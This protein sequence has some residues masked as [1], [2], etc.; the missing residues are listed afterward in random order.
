MKKHFTLILLML[1]SFLTITAC[2]DFK[3]N[4]HMLEA[5][6]MAHGGEYN[7]RD[8]TTRRA[9]LTLMVKGINEDPYVL[10]YTID[11]RPGVGENALHLIDEQTKTLVYNHQVFQGSEYMSEDMFSGQYEGNFP[12]GSST[13]VQFLNTQSGQHPSTGSATFLSPKLEPGMHVLAYTITNSYGDKI[14]GSKEFSIQ[15]KPKD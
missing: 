11:G 4:E 15:D 5:N 3:L 10:E 12:T 9:W 13:T 7:K 1:T 14:N 8:S 6:F 2:N